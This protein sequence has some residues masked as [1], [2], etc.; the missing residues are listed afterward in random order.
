MSEVFNHLQHP[1]NL[2]LTKEGRIWEMLKIWLQLRGGQ[3]LFTFLL[4]LINI[5]PLQAQHPIKVGSKLF[6]E[7]VIL[8]E[9]AVQLFESEGGEVEYFEQLG[10]TRILWNALLE[11]EIDLYPDYTGTIIQ[12][13]LRSDEIDNWEDLSKELKKSGVRITRPIG[14]NNTYAIGMLKSKAEEL[15]I[16]SISDLAKHQEL[17]LGFSNEFLNRA[18]GWIGLQSTYQLPH[19]NVT[20]LDHDLAYRG[21]EAGNIDVIDLYSTDAEI[22][23]YNL[24]VLEDDQSFFPE[25]QAVFVYRTDLPEKI[26][27]NFIL[28]SLSGKISEF[29][30]VE[31]NARVKL[32]GVSDE[33][34]AAEFLIKEFGLNTEVTEI[35]IWNRLW[36]NTLG[37]LYLVSISL[38]LAIIV[39]IPLGILAVKLASIENIVIG[40]V[41]ILQTIPSLA[42]LVFM[43]PLLGIG[44]LPAMAALFLYSLLPIVRN[45]HAGI[46]NI[47]SP[48]MESAYALGLPN[49]VV[50]KKI[51][52]PLALPSIL[53][54]IKTSAVINV[55]TATLGALIGAGGYGQPILTGIRLDDT[56]LILEGA[57]PAAVLALLVQGVFDL[58]EKHYV[59]Y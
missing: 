50:L 59:K 21:L 43:I 58:I 29:E 23:Y 30:M 46:K 56:S 12:E 6:T 36:K 7:S 28:D 9:I 8:G 44:A 19:Q 16:N 41:G 13:I 22:E 49:S 52:I 39:A 55:G 48:L 34:V 53:A 47:P 20:G 5:L 1:L 10:G 24:M 27:E 40:I 33:I 17:K 54:G 26:M 15:E 45:T 3:F 31:M 57:I 14:F 2:L 42:L 37:H 11:G 32:E 51:E 38:G 35:T 18:D 25:Y 4:I